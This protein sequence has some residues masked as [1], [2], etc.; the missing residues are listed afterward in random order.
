MAGLLQSPHRRSWLVGLGLLVG[1]LLAAPVPAL[2]RTC[3]G[4]CGGDGSVTV[5]E[6]LILVNIAIGNADPRACPGVGE[7]VEIDTIVAAVGDALSGCEAAPGIRVGTVNAAPGT[8]VDLVVSLDAAFTTPVFATLNAFALPAP[9]TLVGDCRPATGLDGVVVTFTGT[10]C[11]T[12]NCVRGLIIGPTYGTQ[13]IPAGGPLFV[14]RVRVAENAAP[15]PLPVACV[16]DATVAV[17]VAGE[18]VDAAAIC[19]DGTVTV[20]P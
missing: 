15:G 5:D 19:R 17:E 20:T 1:A 11:P 4:D 7:T 6:I 12:G 3:T 2:A 8:I 14:C 9:L 18:P 10:D 13:P 16:G